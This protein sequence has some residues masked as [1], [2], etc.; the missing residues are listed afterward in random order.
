MLISEVSVRSIFAPQ[1]A[2]SENSVRVP[3]SCNNNR[4]SHSP[5]GRT[6]WS[7]GRWDKSIDEA[8]AQ[9]LWFSDHRGSTSSSS[10]SLEPWCSEAKSVLWARK[11]NKSASQIHMEHKLYAGTRL[12]TCAMYWVLKREVS[13]R[14]FNNAVSHAFNPRTHG[15]NTKAR[16]GN[17]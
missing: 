2:W 10:A 13:P 11:T 9:K 7:Q 15:L 17:R 14:H 3:L 16:K 1:L 8:S 6:R 4:S 5:R 12:C